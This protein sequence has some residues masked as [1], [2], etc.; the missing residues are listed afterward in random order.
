MLEGD[1]QQLLKTVPDLSVDSLVT[2]PPAGIGFMNKEWDKDKGGRDSWIRWLCGILLECNRVLKPG[3][4][5]LV[6][7][8][9]RTSHWTATSIEEA[10]FDVR[11]IV[12][13]HFSTGFPKNLNVGEGRGTAIKPATEHWILARAPLDGTILNTVQMWG[14]G[15]LNIDLCRISTQDNI[16]GGAYAKDGSDRYDGYESWRFKRLGGAGDFV[17]PGGRWPADLILSHSERC[18]EAH[19]TITKAKP[20][21]AFSFGDHKGYEV[22]KDERVMICADDC[23]VKLLDSQAQEPISQFYYV[24][25]PGRSERDLGLDMFDFKTGGELTN[26]K[27]GSAGLKNPRAGAGRTSGGKNLHPTCKSIELMEYLCRLVTPPSGL[28]LDPFAGSGSTGCGALR[29]GFRFLGME[30]DA[31][32]YKVAAA[33]VGHVAG[34]IQHGQGGGQRGHL[35]DD[36][37]GV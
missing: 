19:E 18:I 35:P 16:S 12:H 5:I 26:R 7:A 37:P 36:A 28:V 17:H 23:P 30:L 21:G 22:V 27:E 3:S 24:I 15:A 33:R 29:E 9:P 32:Y 8:I 13:H 25:K 14:T 20:K 4:H 2:D 34:Q 1:S 6:W 10:G 31:D 11:G